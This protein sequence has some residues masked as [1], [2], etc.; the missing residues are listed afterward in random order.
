MPFLPR[1]GS[2]Y[3]QDSPLWGLASFRGVLVYPISVVHDVDV[4]S[5][6]SPFLRALRIYILMQTYYQRCEQMYLRV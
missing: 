4:L 2:G 3:S 1:F 6:F 5:I